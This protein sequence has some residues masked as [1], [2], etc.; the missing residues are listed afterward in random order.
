MRLLLQILEDSRFRHFLAGGILPQMVA[1]APELC[2]S[3][4]SRSIREECYHLREDPERNT[5]VSALHNERWGDLL[6]AQDRPMT[7][8][9]RKQPPLL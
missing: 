4:P 9:S 6:W 5:Q 3:P 7:L 2:P 1:I 8:V